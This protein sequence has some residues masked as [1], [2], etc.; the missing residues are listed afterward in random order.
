MVLKWY[1]EIY[2][3]P[4]GQSG[5]FYLSHIESELIQ[6]SLNL[7]WVFEIEFGQRFEKDF[8]AVIHHLYME[9]LL[10]EHPLKQLFH[11]SKYLNFSFFT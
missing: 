2:L 3:S 11:F 8:S 1:L 7:M 6:Q 4:L 5:L 9:S 10:K